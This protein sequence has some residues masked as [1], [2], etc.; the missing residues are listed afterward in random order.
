[1]SEVPKIGIFLYF[2]N[3]LRKKC[4]ANCDAKQLDILW[5]LS[6]HVCCYLLLGGCGDGTGLSDHKH[7]DEKF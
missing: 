5:R 4:G 7:T 6:S 1:M 2:C 3:T